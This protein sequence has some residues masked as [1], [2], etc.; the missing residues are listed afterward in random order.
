MPEPENDTRPGIAFVTNSVTPYGV[1]LLRSIAAGIPELKLHTLI[2]HGTATFGW[3]VD[4]PAEI[5]V[6]RFGAE[7]EHPLENP[8]RRPVWGWRKGGRLIRYV[9]ENRLRAVIIFGYRFIS[10][11]RLMNYCDRANIP[12]FINSDSNIRSEPRLSPVQKLTKR[13]IYAWWMKR[14]S[15]VMSMG[16]LGDQFFLKYGAD[17]QRLYRV[18]YW[19]DLDA[20]ARIDEIGLARFRQKFRLNE[21]RRY[22]L[23]SG[24]LVP[25]KRVDL[26][27][28]A[29]VAIASERPEWDLLIVGDGVL[30]D[31]L[32]CRVPE[33]LRSRVVWTGFLD[34]PELPIA[35][36]AADVLVLPSDHEPWALVVPEAMAA[37]LAVVSSDV[38]GA[39]CE[40]IENEHGGRIFPA[41]KLEE[42]QRALLQ[43]TAEDTL[44]QYKEQS[45]ASLARWRKNVDPIAEIR[46]A[47]TDVGVLNSAQDCMEKSV[48]VV[49]TEG[50]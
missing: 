24:R 34:G 43:I 20:Y 23:Y 18:P 32:R 45:I 6:T 12:F 21:R 15:G 25:Q 5:H 7:G 36:H 44:A 4:T 46:R 19:P 28:D 48:S 27:I 29:F 1:N 17:P 47:L 49:S 13:S 9:Q 41:G 40:M 3:R 16:K 8:L 11:L 38:S 2:T 50:R 37:G 30:S 14:A 35:Y 31:E 39:A 42:L 26:L 22:L 33:G 10:Y